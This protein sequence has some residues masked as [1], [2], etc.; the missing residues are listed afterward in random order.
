MGGALAATRNKMCLY[1][2]TRRPRC[3]P[4]CGHRS[5]RAWPTPRLGGLS[6]GETKNIHSR[7]SQGVTGCR[8]PWRKHLWADAVPPRAEP[9]VPAR[10][11]R[12]QG[13][14]RTRKNLAHAQGS[15]PPSSSQGKMVSCWIRPM[16]SQARGALPLRLRQAV[17]AE[18]NSSP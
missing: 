4:R 17:L 18:G 12:A 6:M 14:E 1:Q 8:Y 5:S 11:L 2:H 9:V 13:F 3:S 15:S 16:L 10:F 7:Q